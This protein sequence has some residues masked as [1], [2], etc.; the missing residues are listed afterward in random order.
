M[1]RWAFPMWLQYTRGLGRAS[2]PV[3]GSGSGTAPGRSQY[4]PLS[5]IETEHEEPD[6]MLDSH[7]RRE[8]VVR[9]GG[10]QARGPAQSHQQGAD[11]QASAPDPADVT[12]PPTQSESDFA[13]RVV[14]WRLLPLVTIIYLLQCLDKATLSF[15]SVYGLADDARLA[16]GDLSWLGAAVYFPQFAFQFPVAHVLSSFPLAKTMFAM[17]VGWGSSLFLMG[18]A[19]NFASLMATRVALGFFETGIAPA[20]IAM[21]AEWYNRQEWPTRIAMWYS[22][23]GIAAAVCAC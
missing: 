3:L 8:A 9:D 18:F 16:D 6:A 12:T 10:D 11:P 7:G 17:I 4:Q 13:R 2:D 5:T 22:M 21:N 23:N 20:C 19:T 15:A 14:D 1:A